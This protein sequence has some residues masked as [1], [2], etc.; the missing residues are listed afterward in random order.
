MTEKK[1][2][3]I[4]KGEIVSAA[5]KILGR[6]G[7]R[8]LTITAI[9][10]TAGMSEANI[11]RHFKGKEAIYSSLVDFIGSEVMGKAATIAAGSRSPREKLE[12][13]FFS[14]MA[15][16]EDH[17]GMPRMIFSEDI[18]L[19]NKKLG[20]KISMRLRSYVETLAGVI[21]AGINE[22]DF[23]PGLSPRETA[24]TFL[25]LI[26]STALRWTIG[27]ESFDFKDE[28]QRLWSNFMRLVS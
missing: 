20:E 26:Q 1:S 7:A 4:R 8:G 25:G 19:G 11:Y 21:A 23:R 2:T 12:A 18:R 17:P 14:Y 5:F 28:A 6:D 16:V 10:R 13:I 24:L 9:A 3:D 27:T 15:L 22:G